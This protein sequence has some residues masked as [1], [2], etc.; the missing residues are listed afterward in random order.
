LNHQTQGFIID[1]Y[2]VYWVAI[3]W[4]NLTNYRVHGRHIYIYICIQ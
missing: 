2:N 3:I 4:H 1:L